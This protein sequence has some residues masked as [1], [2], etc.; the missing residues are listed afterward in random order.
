M[1]HVVSHTPGPWKIVES[2]PI[3][4]HP[5]YAVLYLLGE[6][7]VRIATIEFAHG[8][9][10]PP[11]VVAANKRLI[12]TAPDLLAELKTVAENVCDWFCAAAW[13]TGRRPPHSERCQRITALIA[14]AEERL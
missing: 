11:E 12:E 3:K 1:K 10:N 6:N 13:K 5:R 14:K 9:L 4:S 7:G 8:P 2:H